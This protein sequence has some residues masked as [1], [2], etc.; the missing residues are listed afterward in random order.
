MADQ[1]DQLNTMWGDDDENF[2]HGQKKDVPALPDDSDTGDFSGIQFVPMATPDATDRPATDPLRWSVYEKQYGTRP[3]A[4]PRDEY[5]RNTYVLNHQTLL[6]RWQG[7]GFDR[8]ID[9][10]FTGEDAA[11][12]RIHAQSIRRRQQALPDYNDPDDVEANKRIQI[13]IAL[14]R[15][16]WLKH[17]LQNNVDITRESYFSMHTGTY[18]KEVAAPLSQAAR[19]R[20]EKDLMRWIEVYRELTGQ[21]IKRTEWDLGKSTRDL[22]GEMKDAGHTSR[23][24]YTL[25]ELEQI[26]LNGGRALP[27]PHTVEAEIVT[28]DPVPTEREA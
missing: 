9:D 21:N 17:V 18:Y 28:N 1:Y 23:E 7:M 26:A 14:D 11:L 13:Q 12:E 20:A 5:V 2:P 25:D 8:E 22:L 15:I 4:S 16:A 27:S 10:I 6:H 19:S 3:Y 24:G